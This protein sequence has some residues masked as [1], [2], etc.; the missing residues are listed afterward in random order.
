M[1]RA[2]DVPAAPPVVPNLI[3][4]LYAHIFSPVDSVPNDEDRTFATPHDRLGYGAE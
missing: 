2:F 3:S 1:R 4:H